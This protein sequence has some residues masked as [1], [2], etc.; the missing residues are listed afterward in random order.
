MLI[1]FADSPNGY[2]FKPLGEAGFFGEE[3]VAFG[4]DCVERASLQRLFQE[5]P[6]LITCI[7]F[8]LNRHTF[9]N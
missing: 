1:A 2:V 8:N 7:E 4:E 3:D 6:I 9:F 5:L